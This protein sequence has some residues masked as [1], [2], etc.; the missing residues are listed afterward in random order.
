MIVYLQ[1]FQ[2][3]PQKGVVDDFVEPGRVS[4]DYLPK[5]RES[6]AFV[7]LIGFL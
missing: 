6:S 4:P 1:H 7:E 3:L 2:Q 5:Q